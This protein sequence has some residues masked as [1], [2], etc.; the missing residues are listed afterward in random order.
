MN[1]PPPPRSLRPDQDNEPLSQP[2]RR[3]WLAAVGDILMGKAATLVLTGVA[4]FAV[5]K[6]KSPMSGAPAYNVFHIA[7]GA[8]GIVASRNPCTARAFNLGF[9]VLDLYQNAA[10][11]LRWFPRKWFRWKPLDDVLHAFVGIALVAVA[12]IHRRK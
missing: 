3:F 4:G 6:D 7:S 9:G 10:S 8:V 5:P 1:A 12:L 2:P 11:H